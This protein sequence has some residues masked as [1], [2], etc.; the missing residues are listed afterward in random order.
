MAAFTYR[1]PAG[2]PGTI[3]RAE[4][5]HVEAQ[6]MDPVT[7]VTEFGVPCKIV[8]GKVQ[9]LAASD[10]VGVI[11]GLLARPY[12]TQ[13]A[14]NEALG[15]GTPNP[16][17]IAN[18]MKRGYMHVLLRGAAA[19]VKNGP[20]YIRVATPATGKPIGGIEAA[21]DSTNTVVLPNSYFMGPA[22][23]AGNIEIAYNV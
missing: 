22:D 3:N 4:H 19:A 17:Q 7:P 20:V 6:V 5:A 15:T 21:S 18:V 11:Y 13:A 23:A 16:T 2:I 1:M 10:A 8:S 9:P 12:P 14:V